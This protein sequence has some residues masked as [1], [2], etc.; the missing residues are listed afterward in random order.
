[1]YSAKRGTC[2]EIACRPSVRPS[3]CDVVG[4]GSHRLAI[5]EANC[6]SN[7]MYSSIG[8]NIKSLAVF[9]VRC[10]MSD[11]QVCACA[12]SHGRNF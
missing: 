3:V 7:A 12:P 9:D 10:P 6:L 1:M 2:I 4:S 5:L 11:V 8:Q